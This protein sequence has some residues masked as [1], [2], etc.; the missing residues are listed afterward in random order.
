MI[1]RRLSRLLPILLLSGLVQLSCS[2]LHDGALKGLKGGGTWGVVTDEN[3]LP[4][5]GARVYAYEIV[6]AEAETYEEEIRIEDLIN[7]ELRA[8]VGEPIAA[9]NYKRG[10]YYDQFRGPADYISALTDAEGRYGLRL[11]AGNYCLVARKRAAGEPDVGPLTPEDYSSL[12]SPPIEIADKQTVKLDLRLKKIAGDVLFS[13]QYTIRASNTL[14]E[15]KIMDEA[16]QPLAGLLVVANRRPKIG[17]KPDYISFASEPDGSFTIYLPRGGIYY[18]RLKATVLGE[19]LPCMIESA[20]V[21][22]ADNTL[23]LFT[24]NRLK[25]INIIRLKEESKD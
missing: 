12:V 18:L 11:P 10:P 17:R 22:P 4:V 1:R 5:A 9:A 24:G 15:G 14:F 6:I 19:Y 2:V 13:S 20:Y 8:E 25:G 23:E 21:N 3:N 7:G 16:G